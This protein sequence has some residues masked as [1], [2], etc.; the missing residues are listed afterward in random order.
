[1]ILG[2]RSTGISSGKSFFSG[3]WSSAVSK[4]SSVAERYLGPEGSGL[5]G[6]LGV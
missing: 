2:G 5:L 3:V 6:V 4:L 1:M